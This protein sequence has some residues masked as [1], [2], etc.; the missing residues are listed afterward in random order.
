[1]SVVSVVL[2][3]G[4]IA[5]S[6]IIGQSQPFSFNKAIAEGKG[7][8]TVYV[9]GQ[10]KTF[11]T[12][13]NTIGE[14]LKQNGVELGKGDV[15]EPEAD[16]V[17]DQ[18]H[19]NVNIYKAYPAI[20]IDGENKTTTLSGYRTARQIVEA[21]GIK[22][23]PE[24]KLSMERSDNFNDASIVGQK[25]T[26]DR[27]T[28][29]ELNLGN[30]TFEFRTWQQT[31]GGLLKEKGIVLGPQDELNIDLNEKL[32]KNMKITL[33][34]ISQDVI[35]S[36][37]VLEP[38]VQYKDDPNQMKNYQKVV[39]EGK[40]GQKLV[41]Y[42]INQKNGVVIDKQIIDI[43]VVV[44]AEPKI[45]IRGTRSDSIADNSELLYKLRMCETGGRYNANT[46]NG[47]YG[48]YQFSAATWNRW[49]TGYARADLAPPAVQDE[50]VLKN[51]RA[52]AGGFWSQHPG[53]SS[54][55]SLPKFPY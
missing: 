28:P 8:I 38:E 7:L 25:I 41:S 17:I 44:P 34:K 54:K 13:A 30:K 42:I 36:T 27:A 6:A 22:I 5:Y 37:E 14:A 53:C 51:S 20:I 40:P 47:Y 49:N 19:Y 26:I 48:A 10:K 31:V 4:F 50:Y 55:L 24:D 21:A 11:A 52:S 12:N 45:V 39:S 35:Q 15:I 2:L 46:G 18:P 23:Y 9:D 33:N 16:T 32:Y 43:K 29:V 3:I 1:M